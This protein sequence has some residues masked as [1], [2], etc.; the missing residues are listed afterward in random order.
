MPRIYPETATVNDRI[1]L[2]TRDKTIEDD[3]F[4]FVSQKCKQARVAGFVVHNTVE[5][6]KIGIYMFSFY[7]YRD[8]SIICFT[9]FVVPSY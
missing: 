6:K 4:L 3:V 9:A 2:S 8:K 5:R 1:A 7:V